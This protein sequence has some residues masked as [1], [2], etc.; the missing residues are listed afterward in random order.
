MQMIHKFVAGT[1][2]LGL[3]CAVF[4]QDGL[5][6]VQSFGS[7]SYITGGIGLDESTSIKAA[8]KDFTLSLLFA[9]TKRGE[10]LADVKVSIK[11]KAG[12]IVLEAVSDGPMLLARLPAGIYKISAEH[13]GTVLVKTVRVD[14]KRVAQAAFVWQPAAKATIQ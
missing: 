5:P 11:D 9:Q 3:T 4:A 2:A 13:E 8:E 7:V 1:L 14:S 12:S 10:Y 6:P